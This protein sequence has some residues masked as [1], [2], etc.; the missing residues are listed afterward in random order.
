MCL[1]DMIKYRH[2]YQQTVWSHAIYFPHHDYKI[3]FIVRYFYSLRFIHISMI[4]FLGIG[5]S[6]WACQFGYEPESPPMMS[7]TQS[8]Q[9]N[10]NGGQDLFRPAEEWEKQTVVPYFFRSTTQ[11]MEIKTPNKADQWQNFPVKGMNVSLAL[12]GTRPGEFTATEEQISAWLEDLSELPFNTLRIYTVQSPYF[13]R[14]LRK[15]NLEHPNQPFFLLQGVWIKEPE[16]EHEAFDYRDVENQA[17]VRDEIEKVIDVVY[18]NREIPAPTPQTGGYGRAYGSYHSDVSP[19]LVGW[20]LGREMEPYTIEATHELHKDVT[21]YDGDYVSLLSGNPTEALIAEYLDYLLSYQFDHYQSIHSFAFSNWPTLDPLH[22]AT[23]PVFPISSE[24]HFTIDIEKFVLSS[25]AEK[26]G[27]F[28]SYHAYPYYPDFIMYQP[29]YQQED[30]QGLNPY[31]GYLLQLKSYHM[32]RPLLITEIGLPSSQGS[33]HLNPSGLHH[34]GLTERQVGSGLKRMIY[35]FEQANID[36]YCLFELLDEWFKRAWI[37]DRLELPASRRHLW[38]NPMSPEQNFGIIALAPGK[39]PQEGGHVVNGREGISEWGEPQI[40]K[41]D[42]ELSGQAGEIK[43]ITI[44]HD[45]GYLH[46]RIRIEPF[47]SESTT[48]GWDHR[49]YWVAFDTLDAERGDFCLD[50]ECHLQVEQGVEFKLM[51]DHPQRVLWMVDRPYDLFGIWHNIRDSWQV[52]STIA[53]QSGQFVLHRTLT[54]VPYVYQE[55]ELGSEQVQWTGWLPVGDMQQADARSN[56][57]VSSELGVMEIRIPWTLLAFTDPTKMQVVDDQ[58]SGRREPDTSVTEGIRIW[59]IHLAE[60]FEGNED[61]VSDVPLSRNDDGMDDDGMND[62]GMNE[63]THTLWPVDSLPMM[64]AK[65]QSY[66]LPSQSFV[67]TWQE[68]EQPRWYT[69]RKKMWSALVE[70]GIEFPDQVVY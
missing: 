29:E 24:D 27:Q 28:A 60:N 19:W 64:K 36:G 32:T 51:I 14:A 56:F 47:E 22:H 1:Y 65:E 21:H 52:W 55:M 9:D 48:A 39:D 46:I 45:E 63:T 12:P 33:A 35:N 26:V 67:Y 49:D 8:S 54:N 57:A 15:W 31:L 62:D 70:L 13:Y 30:E 50:T 7:S 17:W 66:V 59:A 58:G 23:E 3:G 43:D 10:M 6:M 34:G 37:V 69:R 40:K 61:D 44:D 68:W 16:E 25:A 4:L 18:G 38:Y 11:G 20:L 42:D 5:N 2:I 41:A 53:N